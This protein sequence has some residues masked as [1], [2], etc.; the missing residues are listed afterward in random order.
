VFRALRNHPAFRRFLFGHFVSLVGTWLQSVAQSWLVYRLTGSPLLLGLVGFAG[1]LPVFLLGP[2]AGVAADRWDRRTTLIA[3]QSLA[4]VQAVVLGALTLSGS[5]TV[6][7][8]FVLAS[9]LG[10]VN[11]FDVPVRQSFVVE[12]VGKDDLPNA[13]ALNSSAVNAARLIGPAAAGVLVAA[14]GEGWCFVLN[15][16]SYLAVLWALQGMRLAPGPRAPHAASA[17]AEIAEGFRFAARAGPVRAL[18]ALV[19]LVSLV[20]LPYSVLLPVF[21]DRVLGGG[22]RVLGLLV[23]ATGAGALAGALVLAARGSARGLSR[24]VVGAAAGFGAGLVALSLSRVLVLSVV[25]LVA[26]GFCM[27]TLL[28]AANTLLQT[29]APDSFRGRVMALFSMMFLGMAPFGALLAGALAE[30]IGAP[31]TAAAGGALCLIAAGVLVPA[32]PR[33]RAEAR[34]MMAGRGT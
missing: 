7:H 24:W 3:T 28:A 30:R 34:E 23:G 6:A 16:A 15:S 8:V 31:A 19:G 26:V 12:M 25:L 4:L 29:L 33:L 1:Q 20:G 32:L 27:I 11:A 10:C 2:L 17:P 13:I 14:V 5:V 21:A 22:P 18:L 9:L